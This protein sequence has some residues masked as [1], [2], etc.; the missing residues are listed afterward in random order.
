MIKMILKLTTSF[1]AIIVFIGV[2]TVID[3]PTEE[4][5]G[6]SPLQTLHNLEAIYL[7]NHD[8]Y[9]QVRCDGELVNF[10]GT[11]KERTEWEKSVAGFCIDEYKEPESRGGG[12][13]YT[14][15]WED[16]DK[17]YADSFGDEKATRDYTVLKPR[18]P[19]PFTRSTTTS[20]KFPLLSFQPPDIFSWISVAEA[21]VTQTH[22]ASTTRA[23]SE[24]WSITDASQ[25]G[26]SFTG[27]F[28]FTAWVNLNTQLGSGELYG[29]VGQFDGPAASSAY[30]WS[31]WNSS[32]T[33]RLYLLQSDGTDQTPNFV[34][35]TITPNVWTH[36]AVIFDISTDE[37][38]FYINGS[39]QGATQTQTLNTQD[40]TVDFQLAAR[41]TAQFFNGWIDDVRLWSRELTDQEISDLDSDPCTFDNGTNLEGWWELNND[42]NDHADTGNS[43]DLTGT[44]SPEFQSAD[45]P[46]ASCAVAAVENVTQIIQV[47]F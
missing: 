10:L 25:T 24:Y 9:L 33:L 5:L 14:I 13:G 12:R 3:K 21:A 23:D 32:G 6:V 27:D 34:D 37:V 16:E 41:D 29:I 39:Q 42:A 20:H 46:Y 36:Y 19:L 1:I 35:H 8:R 44:N 31:L 43:N 22:T 38:K 7:V 2:Y 30:N 28:T 47:S 4:P 17:Y 18:N 45:L 26:L 40:S 15:K 11:V